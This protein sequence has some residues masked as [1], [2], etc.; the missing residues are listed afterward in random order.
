MRERW[1]AYER[2]A[3]CSVYT[4]RI[5]PHSFTT[6]KKGNGPFLRCTYPFYLYSLLS[7]N[8]SQQSDRNHRYIVLERSK[9]REK[10][11]YNEKG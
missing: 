2:L 8:L 11:V 4:P 10:E 3:F 9:Q 5:L 6:F 7:L 1:R